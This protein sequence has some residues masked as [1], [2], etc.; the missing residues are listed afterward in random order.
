MANDELYTPKWIFDA[1]DMQFDLDVC[2]PHDGPWHT[3]TKAH[4]CGCCG[5]GLTDQWHGVVF[6]NPPYSKPSYW[7]N[8][9][10]EHGNGICLVQSSKSKIGRAHV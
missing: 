7:V 3:P 6:M 9:W 4:I 2:A 8:K 5:D 1:L 10:I